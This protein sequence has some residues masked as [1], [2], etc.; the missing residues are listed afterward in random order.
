MFRQILRFCPWRKVKFE[1][2]IWNGYFIRLFHDKNDIRSKFICGLI[3]YFWDSDI[4]FE[5]K[6]NPYKSKK[7]QNEE[8]RYQWELQDL[9][10]NI[11]TQ[12]DNKKCGSSGISI[13]NS[14]LLEKVAD[15]RADKERAIDLG[16]LHPHKQY[17]LYVQFFADNILP[18]NKYLM[19][20]FDVDSRGNY[21]MQL[22]LILFT[23][24]M[25]GL[26][27]LLAKACDIGL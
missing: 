12:G 22:F 5:M 1:S 7:P 20:S 11:I 4:T 14:S 19:A 9:D 27:A 16:G 25:S 24:F 17:R 26:F 2:V 6:I 15:W 13:K 23:I 3:P 18:S 10:G 8:W 21:Q